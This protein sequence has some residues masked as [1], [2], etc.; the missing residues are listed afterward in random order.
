MNREKIIVTSGDYDIMSVKDV[1]FLQKCKSLGDWLIVGLNSDI[2][3]HMKNGHLFNDYEDRLE[4]LSQISSV[5][6]VLKYNDVDGTDCN[7]LKLV[8]LCYP[9]AVI[10]YVSKYDMK[11]M[12][13]AKIRGIKFQVI[14]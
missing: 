7:L 9:Q 3:S 11:N 6:E 2:V 4:M 10:T 14:D 1:R 12:P 13:E 8:K 5:D